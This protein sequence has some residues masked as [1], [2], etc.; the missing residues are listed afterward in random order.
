MPAVQA[1]FRRGR[2]TRDQIANIRWIM[3]KAREHQK[4]VYLCFIDYSKAF[5]CVNHAKLWNILR[6]MGVPEHLILLMRN[7]YIGQE[8]TVR[9]EFGETEW[10]KI[11][12]G[13][14]GGCILSPYLF[15]CYSEYVMRTAQL[16]NTTAGI[17]I[18][19][20]IIIN[21]RYTDDTTL[22]AENKEDLMELIKKVKKESAKCGLMLNIK[23]TK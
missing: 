21:L 8:A 10:F 4:D 1:G 18:G 16:E 7:L 6:S 22:L 14:R 23:K 5:D 15:N 11:R 2:G 9:T 17:H 3:E 19:G 13:V 20:E 12:N